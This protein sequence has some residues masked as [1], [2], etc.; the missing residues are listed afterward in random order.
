MSCA[1]ELGAKN[2]QILPVNHARQVIEKR[3]IGEYHN[4]TTFTQDSMVILP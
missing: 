2:I 3:E 1:L 4:K